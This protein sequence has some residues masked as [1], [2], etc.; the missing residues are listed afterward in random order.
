MLKAYSQAQIEKTHALV[1]VIG[2]VNNLL[3]LYELIT[4]G[5]KSFNELKRMTGVNAV[6]L[7]KKLNALKQQGYIDCHQQGKENHYYPTTQARQLVPLIKEIERTVLS[8]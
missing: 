1:Q 4:F 7:T 8:P 5:E 3:V 6:T 2:D